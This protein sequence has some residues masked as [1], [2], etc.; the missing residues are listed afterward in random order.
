MTTRSQQKEATRRAIMDAALR[1]SAKRGFAGLSLR[2]VA[3]E[4]GIAPA[5]FYRHFQSI[6]DLG[7]ALVDQIGMT[8]RQLVREARHRVG[9]TLPRRDVVAQSVETFLEYARSQPNLF[10]LLL[11]E[12]AGNT[13]EFRRAVAKEVERFAEDLAEYLELEA[14]VH[15]RPLAH[16]REAAEAMVTVAFNLGVVSLDLRPEER[17]RAQERIILEVGMILRGAQTMAREEPE[18]AGDAW[19]GSTWPVGGADAEPVGTERAATE[20]AE[21]PESPAGGDFRIEHATSCSDSGPQ[22]VTMPAP[23]PH[24]ETLFDILHAR[25]RDTPDRQAFS[26]LED[27]ESRESVVSYGELDRRARAIAAHLQQRHVVGDRVL[28][29]YPPGLDFVTAFYACTYAG[30]VAVPAY[31]PDPTRLDRTL[32]RLQAI[33]SDCGAQ[34]VLTTSVIQSMA[35]FLFPGGSPLSG[36]T[37]LASD[38]LEKGT[39]DGWVAPAIDAESVAFLQY[40]SGSTGAPKGVVITHRN[41]LVN[42]EMMR[43]VSGGSDQTVVLSWVP[44]YHDLG[45]IGG[46]VHPVYVGGRSVLMSPLDFLQKPVRWLRAVTRHRA[47]FSAGPN[48][49]FELC[50][51]RIPEAEREGLDLASWKMA[52]VGAE[53]IAASTLE[54]FTREFEPSGFDPRAFF[55]GYGM[56]ETVLSVSSGQMGVVHRTVLLDKRDLRRNVVTV[57]AGGRG[58]ADF[59]E[60]VSCGR[61]LP[62][63]D[64][65]VVDPESRTA[66]GEREIGEIWVRGG[67]V[68]RGY[69]NRVEETAQTFGA[70]LHGAGGAEEGPF[71]RS[72]DLGFFH[73]GELYVTGRLKDLIILR[74]RNLYP[75]DLEACVERAHPALRPGCGAAFS[76]QLAAG[77][78]LV[79]AQEI[80]KDT[81]ADPRDVIAAVRRALLREEGLRCHGVLLLRAGS[82]P[83]TSSGKIRRSACREAFLDGTLD[84]VAR[85]LQ[86]VDDGATPLLT[87]EQLLAY[88]PE[89][90]RSALLESL[91]AALAEVLQLPE[92]EIDMSVPL[93]E[94]G[95]DSVA[96]MNLAHD[97]E[98]RL[99]VEIDFDLLLGGA[100]PEAVASH[101]LDEVTGVLA[102]A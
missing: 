35:G 65:R 16:A 22:E 95:V 61:P 14:Q 1:L 84:V 32:P 46:V 8:L 64:I 51:R 57:V 26:Y 28:L 2:A 100:S 34:T 53:P 93:S 72:G 81:D 76:I 9:E 59:A 17:R 85:D 90:R 7:L 58:G 37:W 12:G 49:A 83:K 50:T 31:P 33:L 15:E 99:A 63:Q 36:L 25:A 39:P 48:F 80:R 87:L 13:R 43:L 42:Q 11:G 97:I 86:D 41:V 23:E 40:T 74:G 88:P 19:T 56:A 45:L 18:V 4:A 70:Q 21:V 73:D 68:A 55:Q 89:A 71:L 101:I 78:A 75:Q 79:V 27:G 38:Q 30:V 91:R 92:A 54:R 44:F 29:L 5:T 96:I 3:T 82:I 69:W 77:E 10:R 52:L 66:R 6:D 62:G 94:S 47:T 60:V 24:S 20:R 102:P 98:A 67:N